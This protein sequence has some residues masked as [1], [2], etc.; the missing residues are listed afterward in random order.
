MTIQE[1]DQLP[2]KTKWETRMPWPEKHPLREHGPFQLEI[3]SK[4]VAARAMLARTPPK[5]TYFSY[6]GS[7]YAIGRKRK[8]ILNT[9]RTIKWNLDRM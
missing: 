4:R 3:E 6:G 9:E 2:P 8:P 5:P 7:V 1:Y